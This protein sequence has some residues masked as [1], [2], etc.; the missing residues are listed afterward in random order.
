MITTL[1]ILWLIGAAV[2][3]LVAMAILGPSAGTRHFFSIPLYLVQAVLVVLS[4][5]K[6]FSKGWGDIFKPAAEWWKKR[7]EERE[8]KRRLDEVFFPRRK[9]R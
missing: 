6:I 7:R 2:V 8:R 3:W 1:C 9:R 4:I 5:R